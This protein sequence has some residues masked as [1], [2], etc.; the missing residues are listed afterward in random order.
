MNATPL[1]GLDDVELLRDLL[2]SLQVHLMALLTP[3]KAV[4][5]LA[6]AFAEAG[7]GNLVAQELPIRL[8][9]NGAL[10]ADMVVNFFLEAASGFIV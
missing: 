3:L 1:K 5:L 6:T 8:L 2:L 9:T 7:K 10:V 4:F